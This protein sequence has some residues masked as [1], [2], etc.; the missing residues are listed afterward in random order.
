[1]VTGSFRGAGCT[2]AVS[3]ASSSTK[4]SFGAFG[5]GNEQGKSVTVVCTRE[6]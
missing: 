4:F 3:G 2:P 6:S 5:T 1:V